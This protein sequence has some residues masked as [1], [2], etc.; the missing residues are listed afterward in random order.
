MKRW[1]VASSSL[2]AHGGL[3]R[4]VVEG[5]GSVVAIVETMLDWL[6]PRTTHPPLVPPA[7]GFGLVKNHS[8]RILSEA[9]S[10]KATVNRLEGHSASPFIAPPL[11]SLSLDRSVRAPFLVVSDFPVGGSSGGEILCCLGDDSW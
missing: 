6:R 3:E 10:R 9:D 8:T 1:R 11:L 4:G 7:R 2:G 5:L